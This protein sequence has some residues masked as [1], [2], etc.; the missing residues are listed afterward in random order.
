MI[1]TQ[2][3]SDVA[4]GLAIRTT[5]DDLRS[6]NLS[7]R[8]RPAPRHLLQARPLFFRESNSSRMFDVVPQYQVRRCEQ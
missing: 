4:K 8:Q 2:S 5:K 7:R 6:Q 1:A 3:H